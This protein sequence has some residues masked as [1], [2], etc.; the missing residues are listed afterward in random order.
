MIEIIGAESPDFRSACIPRPVVKPLRS[1]FR[2]EQQYLS[3]QDMYTRA[4]EFEDAYMFLR[5]KLRSVEIVWHDSVQRVYFLQPEICSKLSSVL[6]SEQENILHDIDF[7]ADSDVRLASFFA[8][9]EQLHN[10]LLQMAWLKQR[11]ICTRGS[12]VCPA[13]SAASCSLLP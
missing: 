5:S 13:L 12:V 1:S 10:R 8:V 2:T 6:H 7:T 9:A 4:K 3:Q 11:Q